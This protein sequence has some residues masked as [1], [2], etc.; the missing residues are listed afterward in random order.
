MDAVKHRAVYLPELMI[1]GLDGKMAASALG[2][3]RAAEAV[4]V[5][6]DVLL[7]ET[8]VMAQIAQARKAGKNL[9][10]VIM[11]LDL[12]AR[13]S[14]WSDMQMRF[15]VLPALGEIGSEDAVAALNAIVDAPENDS[16]LANPYF[17]S[18]AA[19][20]VM[21][22]QVRDSALIA[23]RFL[24]HRVPEVRRSAILVCLKRSDPQYR[25]L[26]ESAAP[27]AVPWWDV[28]HRP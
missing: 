5:L 20:A 17:R 7:H 1:V 24:A 9:D 14:Y 6:R 15:A 8:P 18:L 2:K 11:S 25:K 13:A 19:E 28:Q 26:L 23:S 27:W 12:R 4:G 3:L 22:S 21:K 16:Q 10:Q